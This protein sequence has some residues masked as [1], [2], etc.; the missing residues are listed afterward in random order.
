M[1]LLRRTIAFGALALL[2]AATFGSAGGTSPAS[3][4]T[5]IEHVVVLFMENHSFDDLLGRYCVSTGRCD[6]S[7]TGQLPTGRSIPL[8][9]EPDIVPLANHAPKTQETCMNGG[10][11][12]GCSLV[13]GCNRS[14]G[15][16]CYTAADPTSIPNIIALADRFALSDRTFELNVA[17]SWGGHTEVVA[18]T[19]DGFTGENPR[20]GVGG[21]SSLGWG[22]DSRK[23]APWRQSP[24]D[25]VIRVPSCVPDQQGN[26]PYRESPVQYVPTI[27][28]RLDE[29]GL[30]WNIYAAGKN[31]PVGAGYARAMCPTFYE[32]LST[33]QEDHVKDPT[34]FTS[35]A[36]AGELPNFAV[37]IPNRNDSMHP[38]YSLAAGDD[39]IA[40]QI[41]A[42]EQGPEWSSTAVFITWDDCGCFY[43]HVN[44]LAIDPS[45][46]MRLPMLIVSPWA[47][48]Q[49]T[50]STAATFASVLAFTEH[51]YG[52]ASLGAADASA[53]D[54]RNA[55]DFGES[56]TRPIHL[57]T[58][59]VPSASL[60]AIAAHPPSA[61]Q[62]S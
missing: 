21:G 61:R 48:P 54:Y 3:A 10:L 39:W 25:P 6:G 46:G 36:A 8:N 11:M 20:A 47:R 58:H 17:S 45:W 19:L 13:K 7:V 50:D 43:D 62:D 53:Y 22:C 51:I 33:S 1:A 57:V 31:D 14:H 37:V 4:S 49:Y 2:A 55:F 9:V 5:P 40:E 35:D 56:P 23:D 60:R 18:A 38:G 32:C 52:M 15:Y 27:M 41:N 12:N 34:T 30:S 28:D 29:A 24:D 59:A 26:G 16:R 42:M 44:P